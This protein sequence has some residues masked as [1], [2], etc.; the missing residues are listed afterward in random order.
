MKFFRK[1]LLYVCVIVI[2]NINVGWTLTFSSPALPLIKKEFPGLSS[3]ELAA[4]PAIPSLAAIIG[5][6][7]GGFLLRKFSRKITFLVNALSRSIFWFL[8]LT[9]NKKYFWLALVIRFFN[10][11]VMGSN[12]TVGGCYT[13][14]LAPVDQMGFYGVFNSVMISFGHCTFNLIGAAHK[15]RLNV[16]IS[17]GL[18]LFQFISG[19]FI[20]DSPVDIERR[21]HKKEEEEIENKHHRRSLFQLCYLKPMIIGVS[22]HIFQQFAG[23]N[24]L[25]SNMSS[26]LKQSGLDIDSAYQATIATIA[27]FFAGL[28]STFIMDKL[29]RRIIWMISSAGCCLFMSLFSTNLITNWSSVLPVVSIFLYMFVFGGGLAPIPW[30]IVPEMFDDDVR[31]TANSI[32]V[33]LNWLSASVVTFCFP[34]MQKSM[35]MYGSLYFFAA[36]SLCAFIFG[37]IFIPNDPTI[38]RQNNSSNENTDKNEEDKSKE[39]DDYSCEL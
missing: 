38:Y 28:I 5:T 36:C 4:F 34:Y 39:N 23:V 9:M 32:C 29:G 20:P 31:S 3:F 13:L 27:E 33:S 24:A 37:I 14:E 15:W 35:K 21:S 22:L 11:V 19:L 1:E 10:G 25:I 6:Y 30:I 17:G 2:G 18:L 12:T 26:I 8:T 7:W 16:Y